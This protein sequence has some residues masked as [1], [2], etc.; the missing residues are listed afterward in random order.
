[1]LLTLTVI[2]AVIF[3]LA[4]FFALLIAGKSGRKLGWASTVNSRWLLL[5]AALILVVAKIVLHFWLP[6]SFDSSLGW[7]MLIGGFVALLAVWASSV[8]VNAERRAGAAVGM[9][10]FA[11]LA[12]SSVVL[13]FPASLHSAIIGCAIGAVATGGLLCTALYILAPAYSSPI[14]RGVEMFTI[15]SLAL[16]AGIRLGMLHFPGS[17][18][19]EVA[20]YWV[21]PL[22]LLSGGLLGIIL[23]SSDRAG[24]LLQRS[25]GISALISGIIMILLTLLMQKQYLP[26][27]DWQLPLYGLV[28]FGAVLGLLFKEERQQSDEK[29]R[30]LALSFA[31]ILLSLAVVTLAFRKLGGYG[32]L[33][34]LLPA[35]MLVAVAVMRSSFA[36]RPVTASLAMSA[37]SIML[38]LAVARLLIS[39]TAPASTMDFQ[40]QYDLLAL[41]LGAAAT[42]G[43]TSSIL[44]GSLRSESLLQRGRSP[45]FSTL[46]HSKMLWIAVAISP[47]MILIFFG[48][49]SVLAFLIGMAIGEIGWLALVAWSHGKERLQIIMA[50]PHALIFTAMVIAIAF[51]PQLLSLEIQ[52][53]HRLTIILIFCALAIIWVLIDAIPRLRGN[54]EAAGHALE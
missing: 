10:A 35:L 20:G 54:K 1:M 40:R 9:L 21:F 46:F 34:A 2:S 6:D 38:L 27:L 31:L 44:Q 3:L 42:W 51:A 22:L 32:E 14:C 11:G 30:P 48:L 16:A 15:A 52:R 25:P 29:F 13:F 41:L 28:V 24:S 19:G 37:F 49:R 4:I 12:M 47:L 33:I 43:I 39:S 26:K 8:Q 5:M 18:N 36:K 50:A 7:G 23:F 53:N 17:S 45:I